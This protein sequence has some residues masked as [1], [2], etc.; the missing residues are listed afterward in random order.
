VLDFYAKRSPYFM[1]V[2]F[3]A[4]KAAR[5]GEQIGDG[6]PI[7]LVMKTKQPWVP[8]RIL[9]L[10]ARPNAPIEADVFLLTDRAPNML[11]VPVDATGT[12]PIAPGLVQQR[13][14]AASEL[15]LGDLGSDR[16]MKWVPDRG[17]WLTFLT[18]DA[19]AG[20]LGY[21]LALNVDGGVPSPADAGL[22]FEPAVPAPAGPSML[23]AVFAGLGLL[24]VLVLLAARQRRNG[25]RV[26]V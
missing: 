16:G 25:P 21:D 4:A 1:A 3:D 11:P 5:R 9:G 19:K 20:E 15:L 10:G 6:I 2:E 8:L 7:H 26:A 24:V 17:M 18:L 23:W 22:T 12:G 14:E 13:S